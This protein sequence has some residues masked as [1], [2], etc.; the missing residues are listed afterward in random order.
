MIGDEE[1]HTEPGNIEGG[2]VIARP[3]PPARGVGAT[4]P[5][6]PV[7]GFFAVEGI[8]GEIRVGRLVTVRA[9]MG[10]ATSLHVT[11]ADAQQIA[12]VPQHTPQ[13]ASDLR[14]V[15]PIAPTS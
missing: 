15:S 2:R 5:G 14:V 7:V 11:A 6:G 3:V 1:S 4:E 9:G 10:G 8:G 13:L 12:F